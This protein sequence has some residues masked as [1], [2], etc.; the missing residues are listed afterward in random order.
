[1]T[2]T[3]QRP[4]TRAELLRVAHAIQRGHNPDGSRDPHT[5]AIVTIFETH[6]EWADATSFSPNDVRIP[7]RQINRIMHWAATAEAELNKGSFD[8]VNRMLTWVN[9][10]PSSYEED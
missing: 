1:M 7:S 8:Q 2:T 3:Q 6:P 10:G 5:D 9:V 4:L